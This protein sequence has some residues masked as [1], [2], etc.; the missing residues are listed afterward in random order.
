MIYEAIKAELIARRVQRLP[1]DADT[2]DKRSSRDF[3]EFMIAGAVSKTIAS[4]AAYPH[5][6]CVF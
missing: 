2:T 4:C 5:G 3:M 6:K 1:M